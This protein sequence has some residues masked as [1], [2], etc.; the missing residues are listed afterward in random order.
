MDKLEHGFVIKKYLELNRR[1]K[2]YD[3]EIHPWGRL[4]IRKISDPFGGYYI[5]NIDSIDTI[6]GFVNGLEHAKPE[7]KIPE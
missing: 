3:L 1:L 7:L 5:N 6:E 2:P 4:A